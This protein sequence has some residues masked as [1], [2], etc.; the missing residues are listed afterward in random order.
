M[1]LKI[2]ESDP[3]RPSRMLILGVE[4]V[5]KS[6]FGAKADTPIFITPEG[7]TDQLT[8]K[9]GKPVKYIPGINSWDT[10]RAAVKSLLTEK[11]DF[12]TVVLDSADWL[13]KACHAKIIGISNKSIITCNGGYG[14]GY[15]ESET[16]HR[17]LIEDLESLRD[18]RG[19]NVVVTA[20]AHVKPVKD[21]S[22]M[23]DYDQFEIKCHE[24]VSSLWREWVDALL[25]ARFTTFVKAKDNSAKGRALTDGTRTLYTRRQPSFQAKNRFGLPAEMEFLEDTWSEIMTYAHKQRVPNEKAMD[26]K[27]EIVELHGKVTD[28]ATR[29]LV[30]DSV[31]AAGMDA[32]KLK[33]IRARLLEITGAK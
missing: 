22:M 3:T 18:T 25:F 16:M 19:M 9:D 8:D 31:E 26:I 33:S 20:H 28:D 6:T 11:H 17:E 10:A 2:A 15:R 23:E 30:E 21:P 24:F 5:G 12:K 14:T 27:L 4:G 13:E 1:A 32:E 29:K 7:G